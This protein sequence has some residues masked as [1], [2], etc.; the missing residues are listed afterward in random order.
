MHPAPRLLQRLQPHGRHRG[1]QL[2]F[3]TM[4]RALPLL[5]FLV[6]AAPAN[7]APTVNVQA[8]VTLG[9][10]PLDVTFT[11]T[12]DAIAYRWNFGDRTQADGPVV[13]HRYG[14]GRFTATVTATGADGSTAR[15][16][17]VITSVKLTLASRRV[18]TYG[19]RL[20]VRGRMVPA[21]RGAP[22]ALYTGETAL[23]REARSEG[24]IPVPRPADGTLLVQRPL[25]DDC[26]R[27]A[28]VAVRPAL[29]VACRARACSAGPSCSTRS[30]SPGD[31][32]RSGS[33]S[34]AP[35]GSSAPAVL[36]SRE[37]A[38]EH[39]PRGDLRRADHGHA[40]RHLPRTAE[41]IAPPSTSRT[42]RGA[43][44]PSVR[45][46]SAGSPSS[47]TRSRA[48]TRTSRTTPPTPSSHSRRCTDWPGPVASRRASGVVC[49]PRT[50]R[51][52]ATAAP[53]VTSKSTR[54]DRCSFGSSAGGS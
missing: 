29:D 31:Q 13:Q 5:A 51:S 10:A 52:P 36:R 38:A 1:R 46:S 48:P 26:V 37:G 42:S 47:T 4:R 49:R 25:R 32:A 15:A 11:A 20:T 27:P 22:I 35:A 23:K 43:S 9:R 30:S 40:Q 33:E 3:L 8:T 34:G 45:S 41:G 18:A 7:A 12:G 6:W 54:R 24:A 50:C 39:E 17:V 28:P 21:L 19:K 14:A 16:S 44:G 53:T 2:A